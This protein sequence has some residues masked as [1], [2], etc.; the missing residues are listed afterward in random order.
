VK[1]IE[2]FDFDFYGW[3]KVCVTQLKIQPSEAWKLDFK[4]IKILMELGDAHQQDTS[5]M[6]N[7]ERKNNGATNEFLH[8]NQESNKNLAQYEV[9]K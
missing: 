1:K 7:F 9:I 5:L 4:E 3:W 6:L 8:M 2:P